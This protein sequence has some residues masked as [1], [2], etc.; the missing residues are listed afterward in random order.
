MENEKIKVLCIE[1]DKHPYEKEIDSGLKSLQHEVGGDIEVVY[2]FEDSC[3]IICA[4]EGKMLQF[5]L[6]RA[7]YDDEGQMY[8]IVA[9]TFLI[10]GLGE[11][12]FTS[13]PPE[14]MEKYE[15]Q[16]H[17][18]EVFLRMGGQIRAYKTEPE[19]RVGGG[20]EAR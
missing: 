14:L 15:K 19:A 17:S 13:L 4:E 3:A 2:P 18:P 8:D 7:L 12:D 10:V 9:G 20:R 6:N 5:D 1:P 11:E 16:F